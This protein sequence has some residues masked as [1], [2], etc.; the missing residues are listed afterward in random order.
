MRLRAFPSGRARKGRLTLRVLIAHNHNRYR[1]LVCLILAIIFATR[2]V[3]LIL[4]L[5]L[6]LI[7]KL[8]IEMGRFW[9][10]STIGQCILFPEQLL[11]L[12]RRQ[13]RGH[14]SLTEYKVLLFL[15][16][17]YDHSVS[18]I[19]F[20]ELRFELSLH[21]FIVERGLVSDLGRLLATL[22]D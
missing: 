17:R 22:T 16:L 18:V 6:L 3:P 10:I 11:G 7:D 15:W 9:H 12:L 2:S 13:L 5:L 14:P 20:L 1:S 8:L 4:L 21:V 19:T